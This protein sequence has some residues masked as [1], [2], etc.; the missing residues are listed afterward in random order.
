V[1]PFDIIAFSKTNNLL[2]ITALSILKILELQELLKFSDSVYV[3]STIWMQAQRKRIDELEQ[4][5]NTHYKVINALLRL[6]AHIYNGAVK[7]NEK[8][9]AQLAEVNLADIKTYLLQLHAW[10]DIN[11]TQAID[12]PH[13]TMYRER[14]HAFDLKLNV[15]LINFLKQRFVERITKAYNYYSNTNSC[16][17]QQLAKYFSQ[18][19]NAAC[20]Q[21]DNCKRAEEAIKDENIFATLQLEIMDLL[22]AKPM[23]LAELCKII[24]SY[25]HYLIEQCI[26]Q[27]MEHNKVS[28]NKQGQLCTI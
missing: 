5:F 25:P 27:L 2:P 1:M 9:I 13:V 15:N 4:H 20:K 22:Q 3:P 24:P 17:Q 19:L 11:Y 6:Y 7:I 14:L 16:R 21:C 12:E 10:G 26:Y 8:K 28:N 18:Q 23:S